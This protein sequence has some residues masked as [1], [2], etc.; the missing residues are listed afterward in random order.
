[1]KITLTLA[2]LMMSSI[3]VYSA[4]SFPVCN[5]K[6]TTEQPVS[7][8]TVTILPS[9]KEVDSNCQN[10]NIKSDSDQCSWNSRIELRGRLI[11]E[12]KYKLF[13]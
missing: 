6:A 5:S 8:S 11:L 3:M 7:N 9:S 2:L 13:T 4:P 10:D 1:M 12:R